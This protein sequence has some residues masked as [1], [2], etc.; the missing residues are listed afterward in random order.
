MG[1]AVVDRERLAPEAVQMLTLLGGVGGCAPAGGLL[2]ALGVDRRRGSGL[3]AALAGER[4]IL[5]RPMLGEELVQLTAP[6]WEILGL[7][8]KVTTRLTYKRIRTG[9]LCLQYYA[10]FRRHLSTEVAAGLPQ[11]RQYREVRAKLAELSRAVRRK[12]DARDRYAEKYARLTA[13]PHAAEKD[14]T[15]AEGRRIGAERELKRL[16]Q[17]KSEYQKANESILA[18]FRAAS[19]MEPLGVYWDPGIADLQTWVALDLGFLSKTLPEILRRCDAV[20]A[21]ARMP[22]YQVL[23]W[24]VE[25]AERAAVEAQVKELIDSLGLRQAPQAVR[26]LSYARLVR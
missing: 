3:L 25:R 17:Q 24:G 7:P 26:V 11:E 10:E 21:A 22:Q 18:S 14:R 1:S 19:R 4:L 8:P 13:D 5:T 12:K 15:D 16:R 20:A 9:D 6:G 2:T 23:I